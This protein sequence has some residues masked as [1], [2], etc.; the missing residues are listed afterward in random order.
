MTPHQRPRPLYSRL[1]LILPLLLNFLLG[2]WV[3]WEIKNLVGAVQFIHQS[4]RAMYEM[5]QIE[6]ALMRSES[7]VQDYL[8]TRNEKFYATFKSEAATV[9]PRIRSLEKYYEDR[10]FRQNE[11]NDFYLLAERWIS[12]N[13][14]LAENPDQTSRRLATEEENELRKSLA[15]SIQSLMRRENNLHQDHSEYINSVA[16]NTFLVGVS[17]F[18]ILALWMTLALRRMMLQE[19]LLSQSERKF[20][21]LFDSAYEAIVAVGRHGEICLA[22]NKTKDQLGYSPQELIGKPAEIL[23][24]TNHGVRHGLKGE[25]FIHLIHLRSQNPNNSE[26]EIQRKGGSTFPAEVS[27]AAAGTESEPLIIASIRDISQI[28]KTE[29]RLRFAANFTEVLQQSLDIQ[30][31][32]DNAVHLLV[33]AIA[34]QCLIHFIEGDLGAACR[35]WSSETKIDPIIQEDLHQLCSQITRMENPNLPKSGDLTTLRPEIASPLEKKLLKSRLKSYMILPLSARNRNVGLM[36]L[37]SNRIVYSEEDYKFNL[38]MASRAA[39]AIDNARLYRKSQEAIK[40]RDQILAIVSHDLK[41]PLGAIQM[42]SEVM[43]DNLEQIETPA[44]E[45]KEEVSD[46]LHTIEK[47]SAQSLYLINDLLDLAQVEEGNLR[48]E[49]RPVYVSEILRDVVDLFKPLAYAKNLNLKVEFPKK[50]T[51][52]LCDRRRLH[53]AISNLVGNSIKF[54]PEKGSVLLKEALLDN[55]ASIAVEDTGMGIKPEAL[56]HIFDR[57][58]QPEETKKQGTGLGLFITKGIVEAHG[59]KIKA[60]SSLGKGS[61]FTV[62]LPIQEEALTS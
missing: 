26:L 32:L 39:L 34:D 14:A 61:R 30:E 29:S 45:A 9:L 59:G 53:Q 31:T 2:G 33:P 55:T 6:E 42:A 25:R 4:H 57:Y 49:K 1:S 28:K 37:F 41:N 52:V 13:G 60:E 38:L 24:P 11:V 3:L 21:S 5:T 27:L 17:A 56:E 15:A 47:S 10:S 36:A 58:W 16:S 62:N 48:I 22:N 23:I 35:I 18:S 7:A 54:T 50:E 19:A 40:A 20:K 51:P 46:L 44:Q 8:L 43:A 12:Y